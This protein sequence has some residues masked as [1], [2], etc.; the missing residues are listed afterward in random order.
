MPCALATI[1]P[2]L[3][4]MAGAP[5]AFV[6]VPMGKNAETETF[7]EGRPSER[8]VVSVPAW[9]S[10]R[11]GRHG[12][13]RGELGV[14]GGRFVRTVIVIGLPADD[15]PSPVPG[16]GPLPPGGPLRAQKPLA[17]LVHGDRF[18]PR[19]GED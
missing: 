13:R 6:P 12:R 19:L 4:W 9:A 17:E 16:G 2:N 11:R 1:G 8:V 5:L 3:S 10:S 15:G 7:E 18:G 14:P